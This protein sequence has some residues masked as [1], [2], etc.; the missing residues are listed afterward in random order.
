MKLRYSKC[1]QVCSSEVPNDTLVRGWIE[2]SDC[3]EQEQ[4]EQEADVR[5]L[6]APITAEALEARGWVRSSLMPSLFNK[7][8]LCTHGSNSCWTLYHNDNLV[9]FP[10][11][12]M[13][14]VALAEEWGK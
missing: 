14:H 4:A 9:V 2:C 3:L 5:N 11:T 13:R 12:A 7:G 10:F 6:D 8:P 1:L